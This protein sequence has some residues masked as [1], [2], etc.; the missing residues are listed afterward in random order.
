MM[1]ALS[2][3][4][5][6]SGWA[7]KRRPGR[8]RRKRGLLLPC[9]CRG[10]LGAQLRGQSTEMKEVD[11]HNLMAEWA[12]CSGR[13]LQRS[14][15]QART[16]R[17][18]DPAGLGPSS[19]GRHT[20]TRTHN[21]FCRLTHAAAC[22]PAAGPAPH[23]LPLL[24]LKKRRGPTSCC[25]P[26]ASAAHEGSARHGRRSVNRA[27]GARRTAQ[28]ACRAPRCSEEE[29]NARLAHHAAAAR[30]YAHAGRSRG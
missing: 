25:P 27:A 26:P 28:L 12:A 29:S 24:P 5:P 6:P 16:R 4:R 7:A 22:Q 30:D 18:G 10:A 8:W 11:T 13:A 20:H 19:G 14:V 9:C 15:E 1:C 2:L 23:Q 3:K 21:S 17:T